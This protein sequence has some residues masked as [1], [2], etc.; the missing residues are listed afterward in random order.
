MADT[1]TEFKAALKC[2]GPQNVYY[3]YGKDIV[4][5]E[6]S[7]K[8]LCSAAVKKGD[9]TYNLHTFDGRNFD[10]DEFTDACEALPLFAD[11]VLCA[12]NDL[13]AEELKAEDLNWLVKFIADIPETTILVFYYTGFDVTAGKKAPTAKNKKISDVAAKK[14]KVYN[15]ELKT[16]DVLVKEI[17]SKVNKAG[18]SISKENA[19]LLVQLCCNDSLIIKNETDKLLAYCGNNEI[20]ASA[21][22]ALCPRQIDAKTYKLADAIVRREKFRAMSLLNDLKTELTE[23]ISILYAV[24]GSMLDMYRAKIAVSSRHTAS[25]VMEDFKYQKNLSFRVNNAFRD[26][27]YYSV[28]DLR[29]CLKILTETDVAMKSSKTDRMILL[30]EAIIKMISLKQ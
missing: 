1:L 24:T 7:Y 3:I 27:R 5:V 14:G 26:V 29:M 28:R 16:A 22:D 23:P 12:V 9:E 11:Y 13:N 20:T 21:I 18:S 30:E 17:V 15:F 19:Q 10:F 25:D 2:D 6:N 4:S 8:L